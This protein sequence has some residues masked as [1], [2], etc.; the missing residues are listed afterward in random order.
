MSMCDQK[1]HRPMKECHLRGHRSTA[2]WSL[3][4]L[5]SIMSSCSR[6]S[7]PSIQGLIYG[8][9]PSWRRWS[10]IHA[11][12]YRGLLRISSMKPLTQSRKE[13]HH[14]APCASNIMAPVL[15]EPRLVGWMIHSSSVYEIRMRLFANS[16][17]TLSSA[18]SL[19]LHLTASS[20]LM[21]TVSGQICY[22]VIGRGGRRYVNFTQTSN[23]LLNNECFPS[24]RTRFMRRTSLQREP[25]LFR[26]CQDWIK[27]QFQLQPGVR[28]TTLFTSHL[29]T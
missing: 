17:E 14:S 19:T 15:L 7:Q 10:R 27:P 2:V 6:R 5:T 29:G 20:T 8:W 26:W 13:L 3:T 16:L 12:H 11:S 24:L 18:N 25:C 9:Q 28:S 22:Q 1:K 4:G 23:S 21:G